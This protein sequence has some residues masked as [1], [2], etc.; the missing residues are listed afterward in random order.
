VGCVAS[1]QN[2]EKNRWLSVRVLANGES[3]VPDFARI[4]R[5]GG[6]GYS[7]HELPLVDKPTWNHVF[8]IAR[9]GSENGADSGVVS[10]RNKMLAP[11]R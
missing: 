11:T 2:S 4:E 3:N 10:E 7:I 5:L 6:F 8:I 9:F 1:E